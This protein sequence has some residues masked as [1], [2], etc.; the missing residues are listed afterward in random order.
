LAFI[1]LE[2]GFLGGAALG[3]VTLDTAVL[4]ATFLTGL[5][6]FVVLTAAA[7]LVVFR[8]AGSDPS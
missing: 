6:C 7:L 5:V 1:S 3:V 2:V 4:A 8:A